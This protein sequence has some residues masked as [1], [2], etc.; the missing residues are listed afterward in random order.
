[1]R[2]KPHATQSATAESELCETPRGHV[3]GVG[4]LTE[5]LLTSAA[6][7][8]TARAAGEARVSGVYVE[9][10]FFFFFFPPS[11]MKYSCRFRDFQ[12]AG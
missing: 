1:M 9:G 4:I 12:N 7:L 2:E 8:L 11:E 5:I 10:R 6:R 3:A